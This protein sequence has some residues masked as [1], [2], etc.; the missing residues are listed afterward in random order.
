M[1]RKK[2]G[3]WLKHLDFIMLDG[4]CLQAA[5][6]LA[7]AVRMGP[8][9]PYGDEE[10]RGIGIVLLLAVVAVALLSGTFSGVL[11]R[12]YYEEFMV[13]LRHACLVEVI[14]VLYLFTAQKHVG[15]SRFVI[16]LTGILY[17][18]TGYFSR[19]L[20]KKL[21]LKRKAAEGERRSLLVVTESWMVGEVL[22]DLRSQGTEQFNITGT[23]LLDRERRQGKSPDSFPMETN[24]GNADGIWPEDRK[25]AGGAEK[26]APDIPAAGAEAEPNAIP[27]AGGEKRNASERQSPNGASEAETTEENRKPSSDP[28]KEKYSEKY[29]DIPV[30][31]GAEDIIEAV[32]R[33]WV[34]EALIV[35]PRSVPYPEELVEQLAGMGVVVHVSVFRAGTDGG[36][37]QF[38]GHLGEYTVLTTS[39]SYATPLQQLIK[40]TMDIAGGILGCL[41]TCILFVILAPA[42]QIT[43]PGPVFFTQERVGRNGKRFKIYKFRSMYLDAEERKK[44]LMERNRHGDGLMFKLEGDP[45]IIGCKVL[46]DGRVKKGLGNFMRDYSLDEFPQFFNVLKGDMSLVGTRPPTVDEWERYEPHH[47]ARLAVRPG[48]TGLWQVSGRS[49]I[50]DFEEVVKLDTKYITEW[51][52]GMDF[53]ILFRTVRVVFGRDGAM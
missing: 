25:A 52:M 17:I 40:R 34:D 49:K 24:A 43:S 41:M 44:E 53:R 19:L 10:Y 45:R 47:R 3:G 22:E 18:T 5:F 11:K 36:M 38:V 33:S 9:S 26:K 8:S 37:R 39:I 46:P 6:M 30:V 14:A 20:W 1:Y 4:L 23:A 32:C 21:L 51:S 15:G 28:E 29:T 2:A 35:L 16:Y 50:T 31:A 27:Q 7:Y 48:I 12:G 13:T 42:I